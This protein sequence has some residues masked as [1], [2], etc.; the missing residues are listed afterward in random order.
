MKA[1]CPFC[2]ELQGPLANDLLTHLKDAHQKATEYYNVNTGELKLVGWLTGTIE[3]V[4]DED[5]PKEGGALTNYPKS[6]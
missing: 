6:I 4:L 1:R 2:G 3:M 5:D